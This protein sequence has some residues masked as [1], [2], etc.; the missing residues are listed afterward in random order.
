MSF[1][2]SPYTRLAY[3]KH[4]L[5]P[6]I[7]EP[8]SHECRQKLLS[9]PAAIME[10]TRRV[11]AQ[12]ANGGLETPTDYRTAEQDSARLARARDI[13]VKAH[14]DMSPR[15]VYKEYDVN[16][17]GKSIPGFTRANKNGKATRLEN[18]LD[19]VDCWPHLILRDCQTKELKL[20]DLEYDKSHSTLCRYGPECFGGDVDAWRP[21]WECKRILMMKTTLSPSQPEQF[22]GDADECIVSELEECVN[23]AALRGCVVGSN[24]VSP[25]STRLTLLLSKYE[26]DGW[27]AGDYG[28]LKVQYVKKHGLRGRWYAKGPSIQSYLTR[29]ARSVCFK[30]EIGA[31]V[32]GEEIF[33]D[34]DINTCFLTLFFRRLWQTMGP[35]WRSSKCWS[36]SVRIAKSG[37]NSSRNS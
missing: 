7:R 11:V 13:V 8:V 14:G 17:Y 35:I 5:I 29:A 25:K 28:I 23:V 26:Q 3:V 2:E 24:N 4:F 1:L 12:M 18:L 19:A 10:E 22:D 33:V 20:L 36:A 37:E 31:S 6:F 34:I 27:R 16:K 21:V 30:T 32:C 15:R 9:P